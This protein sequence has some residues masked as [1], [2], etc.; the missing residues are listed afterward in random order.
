LRE[1]GIILQS[2]TT[3]AGATGTVRVLIMGTDMPAEHALLQRLQASCAAHD[4]GVE[5]AGLAFVLSQDLSSCDLLVVPSSSTMSHVGLRMAQTRPAI[6]FWTLDEA[7]ALHDGRAAT[8]RALDDD[9]ICR[10]LGG[11]VPVAQRL[12]ERVVAGEG[13]ATLACDGQPRL[14]L[15]FDRRLAVSLEGSGDDVAALLAAG[16]ARL[17]LEPLTLREFDDGM[18]AATALPLAPLL[19]NLALQVDGP[20][21]L[22]APMD[23]RTLLSLRQWPDFRALARRHDHFRL[24]CLL[25][26]RPSTPD[27]CCALLDLD[28]ATVNGFFNAAYLSGHAE[29]SHAQAIVTATAQEP[30]APARKGGSA[31]A[32]MWRSVRNSM[33]AAL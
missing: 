9:A 28:A 8:P 5:R 27:D 29:I 20:V 33:Q 17:R 22:F 6:P 3:A 23:R 12:R 7:G 19:W 18:S 4:A 15:D 16:F 1:Q 14:L 32:R 24:C 2:H 13:R 11:D 21:P 31:L 25:L 30:G 10:A 26:K